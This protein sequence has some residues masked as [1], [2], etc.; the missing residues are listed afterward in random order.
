MRVAGL[1]SSDADARSS[2]AVNT[3]LTDLE[4][5]SLSIDA[6]NLSEEGLDLGN[7]E[8]GLFH[9]YE[10]DELGDNPMW[11][12]VC[13]PAGQTFPSGSHVAN[14]FYSEATS[15]MVV[16]G[17]TCQ[18]DWTAS[19]YTLVANETLIIEAIVHVSAEDGPGV[20]NRT[21]SSWGAVSACILVDTG[22]GWAK[23]TL[24]R[25]SWAGL[26]VKYHATLPELNGNLGNPD[27]FELCPKKVFVASPPYTTIHRIGV[28][29]G[30]GADAAVEVSGVQ[31]RVYSV[32]KSQG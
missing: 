28:T 9:V 1:A 3:V 18:L 20:V 25:Q 11:F 17:V 7:C 6:S 10:P 8:A 4:A 24:G 23:A 2:S 26:T 5:A 32:K 19:P 30:I 12:S 21:L 13:H 31:I 14:T 15:P 22:S 27:S 16:N 29:I